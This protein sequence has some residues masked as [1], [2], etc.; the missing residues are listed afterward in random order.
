MFL[1]AP[2]CFIEKLIN[3]SFTI[4][5]PPG[6]GKLFTAPIHKVPIMQAALCSIKTIN[7]LRG[8]F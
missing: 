7:R 2:T 3:I 5:I 6:I 1:E 4:P 8:S